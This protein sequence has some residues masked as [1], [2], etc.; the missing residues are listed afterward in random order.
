M[1]M[2]VAVVILVEMLFL[3]PRMH[4]PAGIHTVMR[5]NDG[6]RVPVGMGSFP[7]METPQPNRIARKPVIAGAQ[8]KILSPDDTHI[9]V[10]IPDVRIRN[11]DRHCYGGW[12]RWYRHGN[13]DGYSHGRP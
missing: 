1:T 2:V 13:L 11:L 6:V 9:L 8:I 3:V 5:I 12:W 10:T 4:V 7:L